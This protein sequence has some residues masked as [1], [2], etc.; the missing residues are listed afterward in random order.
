[1]RTQIYHHIFTG[2]LLAVSKHAQASKPSKA[3]L[4]GLVEVTVCTITYAAVQVSHLCL[5]QSKS[6][7]QLGTLEGWT[8]YDRDFDH[9][10][11]YNNIVAL[12]KSKP[13]HPWVHE[14][15]A[16]WDKYVTIF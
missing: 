13:D 5:S 7:D 2:P 6:S 15:Y 1:L 12:F 8:Q 16:W 3:Q 4:H 14:T 10:G 9:E 11:L